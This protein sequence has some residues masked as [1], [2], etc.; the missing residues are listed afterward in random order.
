MIAS[1]IQLV[2]WIV[3]LGLVFWLLNYLIDT[4][5]LPDPFHKVA[6]VIIAVVAV[7]IILVL[8]LQLLG[9]STGFPPLRT[10]ATDAGDLFARADVYAP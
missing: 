10:G 5:P 9:I 4:I 6:K 2:I 3:V 8:V 7:L 1:L